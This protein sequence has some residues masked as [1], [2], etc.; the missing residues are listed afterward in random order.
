M[1]EVKTNSSRFFLSTSM[2][3]RIKFEPTTSGPEA[4][5][6]CGTRVKGD[7]PVFRAHAL[8]TKEKGQARAWPLEMIA[9]CGG[10]QHTERAHHSFSNRTVSSG[11]LVQHLLIS[12]VG[13]ELAVLGQL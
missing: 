2:V 10:L 4:R 7:S 13:G 5:R 12:S 8:G 3:A 11:R 9:G 1:T 6:S